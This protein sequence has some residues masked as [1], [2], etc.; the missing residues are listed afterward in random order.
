MHKVYL[1]RAVDRCLW[2]GRDCV[3]KR[4]EFDV[5]VEQI[6]RE[7]EI[8]ENL[9]RALDNIHIEKCD[10]VGEQR[11]NVIPI[12]AVVLKQSGVNEVA[13]I[14]MPYSGPSLEAIFE[15][16]RTF[17]SPTH[18]S[19]SIVI[20]GGQLRDLA[21]GVRELARVGVVHGDIN[22]RN[23]LLKPHVP[24]SSREMFQEMHRLVLIDFGSVAPD[25][26]TDAFALGQ[27][28]ILC[29]ERGSWDSAMQKRIEIAAKI[30]LE[31]GDF[32]KALQIMDTQ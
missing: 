19:D 18:G 21:H 29:I 15:P 2:E 32:D 9:R 23:T 8:R 31:N 25:Y 13:G 28:F 26:Q 10:D 16:T 12:L 20:T 1:G 24:A 11:F 14:L 30:L 27:L 5:D 4:I 17:V 6:D 22:D 7:I 3:Y